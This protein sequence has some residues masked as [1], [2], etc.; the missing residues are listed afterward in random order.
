MSVS[1]TAGGNLWLSSLNG[2]K[3]KKLA[4]KPK[5]KVKWIETAQSDSGRVIA[6][7]RDPAKISNLNSY[8]LWG[9][10]GKRIVQGSLTADSGWTSY[11][12]PLSL[13]LTSDGKT[14]VYGYQYYSYNFPVSN[15][16][17]GTSVKS[18][19]SSYLKPI[20]ITGEM[21]PT[22]VGNRI[23]AQQQDVF[24]GVQKANKAP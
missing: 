17:N 22:T 6:V 13:D 4:A 21:W 7:R 16:E 14:L 12:M 19:K 18:V 1:Y 8:V 2:K 5:G 11:I 10:T 15:L 9:P 23:V 24:A 3:K 20:N